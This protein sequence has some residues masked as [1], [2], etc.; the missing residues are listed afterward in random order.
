[1]TDTAQFYVLSGATLLIFLLLNLGAFINRWRRTYSIGSARFVTASA[2][3][4]LTKKIRHLISPGLEIWMPAGRGLYPLTLSEHA[5][6]SMESCIAQWI[7]AGVRFIVIISSPNEQALRYWQGLVNRLGA[8]L[9]V[10]L[11]D[12]TVAS[13]EEA[14][15]IAT[16]D[17]FHPVLILKHNRPLGM[18][19]EAIHE[20]NS[21]VAYNVEYIAADNI[22]DHQRDRFFRLLG[23]LR[24]L[25][26]QSPHLKL[27]VPSDQRGKAVPPTP[28][29]RPVHAVA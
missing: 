18:W 10:Y 28:G 20:A 11:L 19:L 8:Q 22:V 2:L 25:T 29:T 12:R 7:Q 15:E 13:S 24:R 27:I 5:R 16:L 6:R 21:D 17:E 9:E 4:N 14:T 26:R 23:V 3:S 1:M